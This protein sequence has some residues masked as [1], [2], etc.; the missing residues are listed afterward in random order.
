VSLIDNLLNKIEK[1]EQMRIEE[2]ILGA[3]LSIS[4]I[5]LCFLGGVAI[6]ILFAILTTISYAIVT[7]GLFL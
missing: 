6:V 4:G 1:Y 7:T 2:C 3:V 5:S